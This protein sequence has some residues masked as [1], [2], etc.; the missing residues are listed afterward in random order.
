MIKYGSII[1]ALVV[2]CM[3]CFFAYSQHFDNAFHFDD[4]HTIVNNQSIRSLSNIPSFFKD[5]TTTSTLPFNQAYR[6]GLTTLNAIDYAIAGK[7]VPEPRQFHISI[8]C[9]YILLG[10]LI[11]LLVF[12]L[13]QR[14]ASNV[15]NK[16]WALAGTAFYILHTAN[17]ETINYIIARSDSFSTLLIVLTMVLYCYSNIARKTYLYAV[18]A[19]LGF[20]VK[21]PSLM[22]IPI[23]GAYV[24]FI[25]KEASIG[26]DE[27]S[28]GAWWLA[29]KKT[30]LPLCIGLCLFAVSRYYTPTIWQA[31]GTSPI[32]YLLT[33]PFVILHYL[34][35]FILPVQLVV[36]TDMVVANSLLDYRIWVGMAGLAAI[37]YIIHR[38][39]KHASSKPIA[40][41]F[42]WFLL[43]LAP[44]SSIVPFAEVLNDHRTFFPYIGL[45]IAVIT[46]CRNLQQQWIEKRPLAAKALLLAFVPLCL[47]HAIGTFER[48]KVWSTEELLWKEATE[49]SP[50]NGRAW[51]NYGLQLMRRADYQNAERC[52]NQAEIYSPD[53]PYLIVNQAILKNAQGQA[54]EAEKLF[55]KALALNDVLAE[56][57]FYYAMFLIQQSRYAEADKLVSR[58]LQTSKAHEK[59]LILNKPVKYAASMVAAATDSVSALRLSYC[60]QNPT[61]ENF[62]ELSLAFY[63]IKNWQASI[64]AA[65]EALALRP[66]YV[67]AYNNMCA[68]YNQ[69]QL[70][71]QALDAGNKGLAID[72]N[73][74]LIK[75][76]LQ[77][78]LQKLGKQK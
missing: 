30:I 2:V 10:I 22:F 53:Y 16:W 74:K 61:P 64:S 68:A 51:M 33:Q 4:H 75:G 59:L 66:N 43:A 14:S 3:L 25:E 58:G 40:F 29:I 28:R 72:P 56:T 32:M 18:P 49:K 27:H 47:A 44:S 48:C 65:Q 7:K 24:Y 5:A 46:Y 45:V 71:Q 37:A 76:N 78:S 63:N 55:K 26:F 70:W 6:P 57:Y 39:S 19:L 38:Y 34:S 11:Y 50:K 1:G 54:Q 8:F 36:D 31:G 12:H 23:V 17:A 60:A 20:F 52:Y 62:I 13:L 21:E 69:L 9:S 73:N 41:G 42:A 15:N 35:N 67:P 77:L